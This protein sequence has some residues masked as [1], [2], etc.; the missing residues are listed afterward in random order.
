LG[1]L[2]RHSFEHR[3]AE[4]KKNASLNAAPYEC[5]G[6]MHFFNFWKEQFGDRL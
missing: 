5:C 4:F 2:A 1:A 6:M 3:I